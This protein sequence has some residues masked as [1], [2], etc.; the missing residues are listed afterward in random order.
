[1]TQC[2][3]CKEDTLSSFFVHTS[4][5][6]KKFSCP[7]CKKDSEVPS[8]PKLLSLLVIVVYFIIK[9]VVEDE[10]AIGF[11]IGGFVIFSIIMMTSFSM[12]PLKTS[13]KS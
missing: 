2:P 4:N 3:H 7:T 8:W 5:H 1:M 9:N 6:G 12:L 11:L 13:S 10:V